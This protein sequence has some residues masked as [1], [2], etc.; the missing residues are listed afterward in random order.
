MK[1]IKYEIWCNGHYWETYSKREA[2]EAVVRMHER[3]D[4]YERDTE[5]YS[6][7]LPVYEIKA[8]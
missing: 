1:K 7:P 5:G 2:A 4:R 8:V 6:N 3:Q